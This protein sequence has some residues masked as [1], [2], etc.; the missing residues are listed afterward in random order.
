[1]NG[2][3]HQANRYHSLTLVY[4]TLGDY[5]NR[6]FYLREKYHFKHNKGFVITCLFFKVLG[7]LTIIDLVSLTQGGGDTVQMPNAL[8]DSL[9]VFK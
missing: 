9:F 4:L 8:F 3:C 5:S 1:M 7:N 6:H 2:I